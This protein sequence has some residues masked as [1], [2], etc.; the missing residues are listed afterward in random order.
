MNIRHFIRNTCI[1][2]IADQIANHENYEKAI[3]QGWTTLNAGGGGPQLYI[4]AIRGRVE[5]GHPVLLG[6]DKN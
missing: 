6:K 5:G 4:S 1:F 3:A 2:L